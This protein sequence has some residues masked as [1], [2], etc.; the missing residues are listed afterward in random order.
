MD[1][2]GVIKG[3]RQ[4]AQELGK[5]TLTQK[6]IRASKYVSEYWIRHYFRSLAS[7][8]EAASL[9]P[10]KLAKAMATSDDEL[11]DYLTDLQRRL[12]KE[13]TIADIDRDGKFSHRV[14]K[15]FGSLRDALW[16]LKERERNRQLLAGKDEK[17]VAA[18]YLVVAEL[19]HRGFNAN[20]LP[21]DRGIDIV[22]LK[23]GKTFSIQV[24][25]VSFERGRSGKVAI[26]V[27]AYKR[28][29]ASDVYYVFVL[30]L[31]PTRRFLV[32]PFH[33]VE[34][35]IE[36]DVIP[37]NDPAAKKYQFEVLCKGDRIYISEANERA[38]VTGHLDAWEKIV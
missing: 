15:R 21:V 29:R 4:L 33:K 2:E 31:Q 16:Q 27:S 13:P 37:A 34:E 32:L 22:A 11:L 9:Q 17:G 19:L 6:D 30:D 18:E 25:N 7:A 35:L 12:Q 3:L 5:Q 20:F 28:Y 23:E 24:K 14:F 1:K 36:I 10:S 8:L 38:E 26:T